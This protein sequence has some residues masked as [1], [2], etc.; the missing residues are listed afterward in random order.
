MVEG[1][2]VGRTEPD[3]ELIQEL[4]LQNE[5]GDF[6]QFAPSSTRNL[7]LYNKKNKICIYF[8]KNSSKA[9]VKAVFDRY[10]SRLTAVFTTNGG[11]SL[12]F[13][14]RLHIN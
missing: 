2:D 12:C 14:L 5:K 1:K 6:H 3:E 8:L 9:F 7:L 4:S 11:T 13:C 10:D